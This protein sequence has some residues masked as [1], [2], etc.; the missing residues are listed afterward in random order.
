MRYTLFMAERI[1]VGQ[2]AGW[3][4]VEVDD[5][6]IVV[7]VRFTV[8]D[9]G[10]LAIA[11]MVLARSPGITADSLRSIPVGRIEAWA[12]GPGRG[13]ILSAIATSAEPVPDS[14]TD[15]SDYGPA[16]AAEALT[17]DKAA[18]LGVSEQFA[19][20]QLAIGPGMDGKPVVL[21]SRVRNLVLRV[22]QGQPKPD[23][24]YREVARIYSEVAV[25]S[26][27][28]AAVIAE[29]N[30]IP[31]ARVHGWVKEARSRGLLTAGERQ[32]RRKP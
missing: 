2:A 16:R 21:R 14:T 12:N 4:L 18:A 9:T 25:D 15:W 29:A 13:G 17:L 31:T 5:P 7:K 27:R 11:E 23:T 30:D 1:Q 3:C 6:G 28:P 8:S 26:P 22:P 20:G 19:A 10:R 32:A 24:F